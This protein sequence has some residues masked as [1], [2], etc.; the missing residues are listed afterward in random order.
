M[1]TRSNGDVWAWGGESRG[2]LAN[3]TAGNMATMGVVQTCATVGVEEENQ[4]VWKVFPNPATDRIAFEGL[5][6]ETINVFTIDGKLVLSL[7]INGNETLDISGLEKGMYL[8]QS[9]KSTIR[10]VK[11]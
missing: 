9:S 11:H 10:L 4:L 6:N 7:K 8:I 3:A 1:G 5:T 2:Q